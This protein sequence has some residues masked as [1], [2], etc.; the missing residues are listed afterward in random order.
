[1]TSK[2]L[3]G[4]LV[5]ASISFCTYISF[6]TPI[7]TSALKINTYNISQD[8]SGN[9][10][11]NYA[12]RSFISTPG[13]QKLFV[14]LDTGYYNYPPSLI[15]IDG[16]V[17]LESSSGS[18][19]YSGGGSGSGSFNIGMLLDPA[20]GPH[21]I[22]IP[23]FGIDCSLRSSQDSGF[24][25]S[26]SADESLIIR[27]KIIDNS[28]S[29]TT[30]SIQSESPKDISNK[31]KDGPQVSQIVQEATKPKNDE[32]IIKEIVPEFIPYALKSISISAGKPIPLDAK[33]AI[34]RNTL[35]RNRNLKVNL[36]QIVRLDP[37][38]KDVTCELITSRDKTASVA[39]AKLNGNG[40]CEITWIPGIAFKRGKITAFVRILDNS[41]NHTYITS[42][43]NLNIV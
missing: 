4:F 3:S 20:T 34:S 25:A 16:F 22:W 10:I 6:S 11:I 30:I 27:A 31:P 18:G 15:C 7:D 40:E 36:T 28:T 41:R 21:E 32:I 17:I 9:K 33:L 14:T 37:K 23:Y 26:L 12:D 24:A 13:V 39:S 38:F 2:I 1:M 19:M 43:F 42:N 5:L 29:G 35:P 8:Y